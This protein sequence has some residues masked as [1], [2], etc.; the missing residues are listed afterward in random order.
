[1]LILMGTALAGTF[2]DPVR[3]TH[4]VSLDVGVGTS[5]VGQRVPDCEGERC[6]GWSFERSQSLR[7][8]SQPIPA[9]GAW[10]ELG[11]GQ[12]AVEGAAFSSSAGLVG[13]GLRLS[14]PR[15][16]LRPAAVLDFSRSRGP[17]NPNLGGD[18][19]SAW[20]G[21][22]AL[23]AAFAGDQA[24]AWLGPYGVIGSSG[25]FL[26]P[27]DIQ[28]ELVPAVPVGAVIGAEL[29]SEPLSIWRDRAGQLSAGAEL[30]VGYGM[31]LGAWLGYAY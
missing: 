10:V 19:Y 16:G 14:L 25:L 5:L 7:L 23:V 12:T 6:V 3:P 31:S 26:H 9:L 24:S 18:A 13:G 29:F 21:E 30:K 17:L 2:G 15:E 4:L 27:E 11:V 8:G 20:R 1:M 22:A 28:L